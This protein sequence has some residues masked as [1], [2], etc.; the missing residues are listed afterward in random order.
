MR[1]KSQYPS[2]GARKLFMELK[3]KK[4]PDLEKICDIIFNTRIVDMGT[5]IFAKKHNSDFLIQTREYRAPE[6]ILEGKFDSKADIWSL[7]CMMFELVTGQH[8]FT[9]KAGR[10]YSQDDDHLALISEI[11]GECTDTP[12]L[13]SCRAAAEFYTATG[14]LK[15][16]NKLKPKNLFDILVQEH[17]IMDTEALFLS[18][19]IFCCLKWNPKDRLS[20]QVLLNDA[21]LKME[22]C[23]E[24][25][26]DAFHFDEYM[27]VTHPDLYGKEKE[28]EQKIDGLGAR[29]VSDVNSAEIQ[30]LSS[31]DQPA[32][33]EEYLDLNR[34]LS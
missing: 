16:V 20:A 21:W 19:F 25:K 5:A 9:P 2:K 29:E 11:I 4:R 17:H 30:Y 32:D 27:K 13:L 33:S 6:V 15:R 31:D 18:R 10:A 7:G 26:M 28:E 14:K 8:L 23:Y 22:P 3:P 24:A 34:S 12:F 1:V